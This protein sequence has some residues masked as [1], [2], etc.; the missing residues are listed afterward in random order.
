LFACT[1]ITAGHDWRTVVST[2]SSSENVTVNGVKK[3]EYH[4]SF[5]GSL[6]DSQGKPMRDSGYLESCVG[7]ASPPQNI[8]L[9]SEP[10]RCVV[11]VRVGQAFYEA[12][13]VSESGPFN[14]F[15]SVAGPSGATVTVTK[16]SERPCVGPMMCGGPYYTLQVSARA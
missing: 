8:L 11:A 2:F 3:T 5:V 14:R 10:V 1:P 16:V 7:L 6:M 4:V 9:T 13:G 15:A 12:A